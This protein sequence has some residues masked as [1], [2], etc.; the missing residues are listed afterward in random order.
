MFVNNVARNDFI[1]IIMIMINDVLA[2]NLVFD[3]N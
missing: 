2:V 1:F 3:Y